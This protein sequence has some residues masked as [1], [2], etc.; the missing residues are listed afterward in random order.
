VNSTE[1]AKVF[2]TEAQRAEAEAARAVS[3]QHRAEALNRAER[4]RQDAERW[5]GGAQ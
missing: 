1:S 4:I 5:F 3:P 2:E